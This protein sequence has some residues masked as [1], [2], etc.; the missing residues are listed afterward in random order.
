[1]RASGA[2]MREEAAVWHLTLRDVLDGRKDV[3]GSCGLSRRE[4]G[5]VVWGKVRTPC[6]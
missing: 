2:R 6:Q 4:P 1:M 5:M 3:E